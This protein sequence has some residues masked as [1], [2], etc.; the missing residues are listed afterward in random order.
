[1]LFFRCMR[2][3]WISGWPEHCWTNFNGLVLIG[4]HLQQGKD[5]YSTI[6]MLTSRRLSIEYGR[7]YKV[8]LLRIFN[9]EGLEDP[10]RRFRTAPWAHCSWPRGW[11][12]GGSSFPGRWVCARDFLYP[13]LFNIHLEKIIRATLQDHHTSVSIGGRPFDNLHFADNINL[14]ADSNSELQTLTNKL[15]ASESAYRMEISTEKSKVMVITVGFS[16]I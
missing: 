12:R 4:K 9:V 3:G 6:T 8:M 13:V 1:M 10:P 11:R 7:D 14:M 2:A 5:L 16:N 15:A